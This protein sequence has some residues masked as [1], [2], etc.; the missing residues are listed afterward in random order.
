MNYL[1]KLSELDRISD[2]FLSQ[3]EENGQDPDSWYPCPRCGSKRNAQGPSKITPFKRKLGLGLIVLSVL[4]AFTIIGLGFTFFGL[5][6]A[7]YLMMGDY[8]RCDDC[9]FRWTSKD[10]ELWVVSEWL[11]TSVRLPTHGNPPT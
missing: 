5:L 1:D 3:Y 9:K 2:E 7:L 10:V 8:H 4:A 6:T 11:R